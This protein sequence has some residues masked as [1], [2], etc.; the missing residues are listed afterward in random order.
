MLRS[1]VTI[2]FVRHGQT[3]WNARGLAQGH[4]D[5]E[6]N[7]LGREQAAANGVRLAALVK[8][9]AGLQ[10]VSSP[11]KRAKETMEILREELGL[12]RSGYAIDPRLK[13]MGFG[14]SEGT[15][16]LDYAKRLTADGAD[17]WTFAAEGGESYADLSVRALPFFKEAA[18]DAVIACHGGISR[19]VQV[20]LGVLTPSEAI[21]TFIPQDKIMV[22]RGNALSWA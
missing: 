9:A 3:Q 8:N 15:S 1:G 6:L 18:R 11:L 20:E 10:F 2:Y 17:P 5:I 16:W 19:C 7:T 12:P 13:E 22:L 14:V 4:S 21:N